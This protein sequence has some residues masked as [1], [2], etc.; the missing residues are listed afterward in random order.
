[1]PRQA[2]E[3]HALGPRESRFTEPVYNEEG[4]THTTP[5]ADPVQPADEG[6]AGRRERH[7][8]AHTHGGY[9]VAPTKVVALPVLAS[10]WKTV[11]CGRL[12]VTT[13]F[14]VSNS[15]LKL[16]SPVTPHPPRGPHTHMRQGA[17]GGAILAQ[18][19]RAPWSRVRAP[20][21]A[22]EH[23]PHVILTLYSYVCA[24]RPLTSPE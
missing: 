21:T 3:R 15:T 1:M 8:H 18:G 11:S 23:P 5:P 19:G 22:L 10:A 13:T 24:P 14:C 20:V 16:S 6:E 12:V 9:A 2:R 4:Y 7:T 17:S